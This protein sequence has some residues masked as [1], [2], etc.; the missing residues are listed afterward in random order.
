MRKPFVAIYTVIIAVLALSGCQSATE[1]AADGQLSVVTTT[2][3][4]ADPLRIIGGD[5][6]HVESLMGSGVDPHL[7]EASQGDISKL[8]QADV[9]FY[10][11]VHLE[12]NMSEV[13]EHTSVPT[14]AFGSAADPAELLEDPASAGSPD[15]H[16]WFDIDIWEEGITAAVEKLKEMSPEDASFFEQNKQDYLTQLEDLK[17]YSKEKLSSIDEDQR[18]LVTAHDAFQYFARM[19]DLEVVALQGLSTESEIGISDVQSTVNTIV[20]KDVP[21][22]FVES[23]VNKSAIQSVIEGVQRQGHQISLGG[24]LYS[25]AM[26]EEGTEAGTYIGMYRYNVDTIYDA[27]S[28]GT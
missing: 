12:A 10:N 2:A 26:G 1:Q 15:P 4:I 25:D 28:G 23:S 6:I 18:V 14:L 16:I 17:A 7:Y 20:E 3:Q 9:L 27:L 22:V 19:N 13:F 21:A 5:R 11:G 8:E 24:E